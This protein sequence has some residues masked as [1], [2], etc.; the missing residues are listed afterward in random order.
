MYLR[1]LLLDGNEC[2]T[3]DLLNE[4]YGDGTKRLIGKVERGICVDEVRNRQHVEERVKKLWREKERIARE[5]E[6]L[7][8]LL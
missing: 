6:E 8:E 1:V 3:S 5:I 4:F 7:N 2:P